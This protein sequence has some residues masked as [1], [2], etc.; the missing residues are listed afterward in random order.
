MEL[1]F[2]QS[3]CPY[4]NTVTA[5]VQNAEQTQE[6]KLSDGMPDIG[7]VL[8]CWGQPLIRSKEWRSDSIMISGGVMAWVLYAPEDGTETRSVE[9]WIPFQMK[10]DLPESK[11]DGTICAQI[12]LRGMDARST[13]AR[14]LMIRS[15]V[16]VFA[17]ALEPSEAVI[18]MP[19]DVPVD[20][21]LSKVNYP[22]ELPREAGEKALTLEDDIPLGGVYKILSCGICP[23]VTEEKVLADKLVFRGA[24]KMHILY[25]NTDGEIKTAEP[26]ISFSQFVDLDTAHSSNAV[27]NVSVVPTGLEWEISDEG[28]LQLKCGLAAQYVIFDRVMLELV[29][30]AYS[31]LRKVNPTVQQLKLP[32]RLDTKQQTLSYEHILRGEGNGVVDVCAYW[33]QPEIRSSMDEIHSPIA[34]QYQALYRDEEGILQGAA[35]R[36]EETIALPS[37]G[38]NRVLMHLWGDFPKGCM[39]ADGIA[40]SGDLSV[41]TDVYLTNGIPMVTGLELG[42]EMKPDPNRPSLILKR[43]GDHSLWDL[44]KENG[45]TV[46]AITAANGLEQNA[47]HAD[48]ILLIPII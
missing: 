9:A 30:D 31:N 1:I 4:L 32:I 22:A 11:R 44:A 24:C 42:E 13:S 10:W 5:Q 2:N 16:S 20:V 19:D 48:S 27:A 34:L 6:V 18:F 43:L 37:D 29:E 21:Q 33:E 23:V 46:Q 38:D 47:A 40:V 25:G 41:N 39:T 36:S 35:G 8:C 14:K 3:A 45:S 7:R 28:K 15:A 17:E 12:S 26:E